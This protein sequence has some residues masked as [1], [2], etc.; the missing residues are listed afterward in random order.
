M[1]FFSGLKKAY[2]SLGD[3]ITKTFDSSKSAE[4]ISQSVSSPSHGQGDL[5]VTSRDDS[6]STEAERDQSSVYNTP[7][8]ASTQKVTDEEGWGQWEEKPAKRKTHGVQVCIYNSRQ[9]V[10]L[11]TTRYQY[12]HNINITSFFSL[13]LSLSLS[14]SRGVW[15]QASNNKYLPQSQSNRVV[16]RYPAVNQS[17]HWPVPLQQRLLVNHRSVHT[18]YTQS[19]A[20][21]SRLKLLCPCSL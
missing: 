20:G 2:D 17:L 10:A 11:V 14:L 19:M 6:K 7:L 15:R 8:A 21:K 18:P 13:S 9:C 1:D 16:I 12:L 5:S 4:D 3:E